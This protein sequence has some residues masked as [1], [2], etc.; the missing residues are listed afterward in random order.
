MPWKENES[1][2]LLLSSLS[3]PITGFL[4]LGTFSHE[5]VLH[6]IIQASSL[7]L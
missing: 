2:L 4:S 3:S 1:T 6:S 5:P 7:K